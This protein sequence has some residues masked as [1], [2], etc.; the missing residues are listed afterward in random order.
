MTHSADGMCSK[1]VLSE[2]QEQDKD[3]GNKPVAEPIQRTTSSSGVGSESRLGASHERAAMKSLSNNNDERI[4]RN[5][6]PRN[7]RTPRS[8]ANLVV[9]ALPHY[10]D[11][12]P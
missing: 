5:C 1:L 6:G 7:P 12:V 2:A 11:I 10:D 3:R 9:F 8:R 4:K